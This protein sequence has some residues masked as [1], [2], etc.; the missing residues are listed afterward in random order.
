MRKVTKVDVAETQPQ[1]SCLAKL[2]PKLRGLGNEVNAVASPA[3][4]SR[5]SL[6]LSLEQNLLAQPEP[7]AQ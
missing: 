7:D 2:V 4:R 3:E 5:S 1:I 6:L